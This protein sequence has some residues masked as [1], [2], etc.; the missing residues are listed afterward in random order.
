MGSTYQAVPPSCNLLLLGDEIPAPVGSGFSA[1]SA[2]ILIHKMNNSKSLDTFFF[3]G[4]H[5]YGLSFATFCVAGIFQ[6]IR[7]SE[8]GVAEIHERD[9]HAC[10]IGAFFLTKNLHTWGYP[11]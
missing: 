6:V 8:M 10:I 4:G 3:G 11:P 1:F 7:T 9:L 5:Y 2:M